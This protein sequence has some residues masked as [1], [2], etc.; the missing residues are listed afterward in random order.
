MPRRPANS[1]VI[2]QHRLAEAESA[3]A[4]DPLELLSIYDELARVERKWEMQFAAGSE[5]RKPADRDKLRGW[6]RRL[7][8]LID[9]A[10]RHGGDIQAGAALLPIRARIQSQ[11][12]TDDSPR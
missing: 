8:L 2:I 3:P 6:Y 12:P 4:L 11:H 5:R 7:S 9:R 1:V 10:L